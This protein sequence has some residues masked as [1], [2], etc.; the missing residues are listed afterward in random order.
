MGVTDSFGIGG[1][2]VDLV[3][4]IGLHCRT[5]ELAVNTVCHPRFLVG[6]FLMDDSPNAHGS[7]FFPYRQASVAEVGKIFCC[8][9][10]LVDV[11]ACPARSARRTTTRMR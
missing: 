10:L 3:A 4:S 9:T 1:G 5:N 6:R 11:M 2:N 8:I 7:K